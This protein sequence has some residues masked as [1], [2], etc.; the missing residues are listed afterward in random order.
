VCVTIVNLQTLWFTLLLGHLSR[1]FYHKR[2]NV[3]C[4]KSAKNFP[5]EKRGVQS[6]IILFLALI[7]ILNVFFSYRKERMI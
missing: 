5:V 3:L 4:K 6:V 7:S 1:E 2:L